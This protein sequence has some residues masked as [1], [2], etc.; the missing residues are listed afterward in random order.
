MADVL[1]VTKMRNADLLQLS[2]KI[3]HMV[4]LL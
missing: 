2:T 1:R 3:S 4:G